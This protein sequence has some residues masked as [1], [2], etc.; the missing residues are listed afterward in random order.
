M[1]NNSFDVR[2]I[3]ITAVMIAL[4]ILGV[5]IHISPTPTGGFIHL[6]D[7]LIYFAAFAFGPLIGGAAGGIGAALAD[8][9]SGGAIYAPMSLIVHGIQGYV[10]GRIAHGTTSVVR[11][12]VACLVGGVILVLGYYILQV[13]VFGYIQPTQ[14]SE[15][16]LAFGFQAADI[17]WNA[18]Q[19]TLGALGA[20]LYLAVRRAYPPLVRSR[21][22]A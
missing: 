5:L 14:G 15:G 13:L 7:I 8:I 2:N 12:A 22:A 16:T 1:R 10:A 19:G 3:A 6:G 4:V 20:A 17:P 21:S 11:L 9:L 18:V